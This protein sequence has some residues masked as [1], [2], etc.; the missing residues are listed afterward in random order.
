MMTF[1]PARPHNS[2][3]AEAAALLSRI[4]LAMLAIAV[5][6]ITT[7]AR[8]AI[9]VLMPVGA[10]LIIIAA[11]LD[12]RSQGLAHIR[13]GLTTVLGLALLFLLGWALL[14]LVWAP[15]R[16]DAASRF[17]K[18]AGTLVLALVVCACLPE[19]TRISNLNLL[20]IGV[21]LAALTAIAVALGGPVLLTLGQDGENSTLERGLLSVVVLLWPA[22]A[23]LA[24]RGRWNSAGAIAVLSA[25]AAIA[26][27]S[28][29]GLIGLVAGALVFAASV[30]HP[31]RAAKILAGMF[32]LLALA[33]PLLPLLVNVFTSKSGAEA[34]GFIGSLQAGARIW[35]QIIQ[36]DQ[37]RLLTGHGIDSATRGI[38]GGFLPVRTPHGLLFEVWF[39][40]GLLGA[41]ALAALIVLAF[42]GAGRQTVTVAP[43]MLAGLTSLLTIAIFGFSLS[44]LWW[45]TMVGIVGIANA[46][47]LRSQYL[48]RR[49]QIEPVRARMANA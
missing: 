29:A 47:V 44:Q 27:W 9:F 24:L 7:G 21:G 45:V 41:L 3:A 19:H 22:L 32:A 1:S 39:E 10:V 31:Q 23:A 30:N 26:V 25:L 28:P 42:I 12:S 43:F 17:L 35:S 8:R 38:A 36:N 6:C 16:F 5:P 37:W 11:V 2:P 4:G 20:P 49:P 18:E 40:L 48:G 14:S 46:L 34:D 33:A 15:F 13:D